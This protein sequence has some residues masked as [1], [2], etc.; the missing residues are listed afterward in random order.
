MQGY[1]ILMSRPK[2]IIFSLTRRGCIE[3]AESMISFLPEALVIASS[4]SNLKTENVKHNIRTYGNSLQ[5]I[6]RSIGFVFSCYFF[7]KSLINENGKNLI[8]YFPVFHPWNFIILLYS[9]TFK[10]RTISTVHDFVQHV[11]EENLVTDWIQKQNLNITDKIIFLSQSE[12]AK[13]PNEKLKLKTIVIPHPILTLVDEIPKRSYQSYPDVLFLGRI[14]RYKGIG[15]LLE[16][17][18]DYKIKLEN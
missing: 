5:F 9:K 6:F 15:I 16:A 12:L 17:Y 2:I 14:S 4:S 7:I 13:V 18:H 1:V 3:Y 11:G 8:F 10:I